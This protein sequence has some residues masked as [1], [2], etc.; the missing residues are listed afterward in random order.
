[1]E[2]PLASRFL[3][4]AAIFPAICCV[5]FLLCV[6]LRLN[7]SSSAFWYFDLHA[8][9]EAKGLIAGSPKPTRSDEWM[10]WTP[11]I[12]AQLHHQP[13]MPMENPSLGAGVSPLLMSVPVRHYSMLFR[14]QLWGFFLFDTECGFAWF[15]NAKIFGLLVSFYLLFLVLMRGRI[16]LAV[17]GTIAV[18]YSSF[19][20]WWFSSPAMLPE[21]LTS[22]AV[23]LLSGRVVFMDIS[24]CKKIPAALALTAATINFLLCCYPPFEIPLLYLGLF[25]FIAFV[26]QRRKGPFHAGFYW[27]PG[28]AVAVT[29]LLW[30]MIVQCWPTLQVI[31]HTSYPGARR[32]SGGMLSLDRFS[33]GLLNFFDSE[34]Q[35]PDI[36]LNTSESANFCPFWILSVAFLIY[37][38]WLWGS[39]FF[40][41]T[42]ASSAPLLLALI[43]F[44]IFFSLYA[45]VGLPEWFCRLT[46]LSLTTENRS[47]LGIGVA[48]LILAVLTLRA[49]EAALFQG[50]SRFFVVGLVAV[51]LFC[52]LLLVQTRNPIFLTRDRFLLL[53]ATNTLLAAAYFCARPLLFGALLA[54]ALLYNNFLVNPIQQG[55][56][57]LLESSVIR[58]ILAI[59]QTNPDAAWAAYEHSTP[60]QLL[61]ATGVRV[62]NGVKVA[63]NLDLM[64]QFDPTGTSRNIYNRYAYIIFRLPPVGQVGARFQSTTSPDAYQLLVRPTDT[65][66]RK[67]GLKYVVL[68]RALLEEEAVGLKLIDAMPGHYF[69]I[70][71]LK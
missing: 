38:S 71:E 44:L 19:I 13:S 25:L 9:E 54:C 10:V 47:L 1:V 49:D 6:A 2:V 70:Y 69:W 67:A 12:L 27:L 16:A 39:N 20:Q 4:R 11:A 65:V 43:G 31:A 34:R 66:L 21:M 15:W 50:R 57:S 22:W 35:H 8:L 42:I 59:R 36:F 58:H 46:A 28:C 24:F 63:P 14:P 33:S 3:V 68:R 60:P 64:R 23:M 61:I 17:L 37:G 53:L 62:L 26:W 41:E 48:G 40:K 45:V 30:P 51:A 52:I 18:S 55:L 7:G 32:T 56:P 29:A 5:L